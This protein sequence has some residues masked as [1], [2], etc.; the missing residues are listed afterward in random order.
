MAPEKK[1][2]SKIK[3]LCILAERGGFEPPIGYEPL[4]KAIEGKRRALRHRKA[5]PTV[6]LR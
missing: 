5:S 2:P 6:A 4:T 3:G 1:K